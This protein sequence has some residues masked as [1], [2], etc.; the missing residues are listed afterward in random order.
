M[1]RPGNDE[2]QYRTM[3]RSNPENDGGPQE[4]DGAGGG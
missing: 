3:S 1:G 2:A 4:S